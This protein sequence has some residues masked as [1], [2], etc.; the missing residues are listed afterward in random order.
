MLTMTQ[1]HPSHFS[2]CFTTLVVMPTFYILSSN[3]YMTQ[4][5]I[6][7]LF[8]DEVHH[9]SF[10]YKIYYLIKVRHHPFLP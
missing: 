7:N 5:L 2:V 8:L 6:Y 4:R 10:V 3:F 1:E 9:I